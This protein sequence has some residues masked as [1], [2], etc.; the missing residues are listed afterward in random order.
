MQCFLSTVTSNLFLCLCNGRLTF[1]QAIIK[2]VAHESAFRT[3]TSI[4]GTPVRKV[5]CTLTCSIQ[6][7]FNCLVIRYFSNEF[8]IMIYLLSV[9]ERRFEVPRPVGQGD[10]RQMIKGRSYNR[11][12]SLLLRGGFVYIPTL[13]IAQH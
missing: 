7:S 1:H 6:I 5:V 12:I 11:N 8:R 10:S 9:S 3:Y 2:S 4:S 13:G